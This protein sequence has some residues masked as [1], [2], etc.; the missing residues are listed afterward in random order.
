VR[1]GIAADE[2]DPAELDG[3][4]LWA[5]GRL[6]PDV[7]VLLDGATSAA[8]TLPGEEHGRVQRLLARMAA[9]EPRRYVVVPAADDGDEVAQRVHAGLRPLLPP[10]PATERAVP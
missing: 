4:A 5:T 9:A 1:F 3:L 2:V 8:E 10:A 6:R 7:T